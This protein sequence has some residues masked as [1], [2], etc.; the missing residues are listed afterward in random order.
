[1]AHPPGYPLPDRSRGRQLAKRSSVKNYSRFLYFC[2]LSHMPKSERPRAP[3]AQD[4]TLELT[5]R[6]EVFEEYVGQKQAKENLL[7]AI[8]A[9]RLREGTLDHILLHGPAGIGK[10]TL[11]HLIAKH[12]TATM[13]VTSGPAIERVGDLASILTNLEPGEVLFIDEAHRLP[14]MVEE[15]LYP[16]MEARTLDIILGKG[17]AARTLQLNL[18]PFTLI[19]ATT[20]VGLLSS[21]LRSRFG[22]AFRLDFYTD[23]E[24][25]EILGRSARLLGVSLDAQAKKRIAKA[26]RQTPRIANRLL[27]RARD[28][29]QV[30]GGTKSPN[31]D[32]VTTERTLS[33]LEIDEKGLDKLDREYLRILIEKFKGGPAGIQA[34][35][36]SLS[37]EEDTLLD[38]VEPYLMQIG[39]VLR[40]PR[41]RVAA[42]EAW[43]HL[44]LKPPDNR[45]TKLF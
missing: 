44:G 32:D 16:A 10:T 3:L 2:Q 25:E 39:Y 18:P 34:L 5:L 20:R 27:K 42:A 33:M 23:D 31:I 12:M 30:E 21:P 41:G 11:A 26:A 6:P 45:N 24:I 22:Q 36:A 35:A 1:M 13:R 37:E 9:A 14:R 29:A 38:F 43:E 28:V 40:T 15:V 8:Q 7:I 4:P 17:T 19:A